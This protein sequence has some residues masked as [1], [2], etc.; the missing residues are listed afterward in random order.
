MHKV[1]MAWIVVAG[2]FYSHQPAM[3]D[4]TTAVAARAEKIDSE[5]RYNRLNNSVEELFTANLALQKRVAALTEEVDRLRGELR[6]EKNRTS[7]SAANYASQED[8]GN[9]I[10]KLKELDEKRDA[11]NKLIVEEVRKLIKS[12][13]APA[14]E[15][16]A[17]KP[18]EK[19]TPIPAKGYDYEIQPGDILSS[20]VSD[21]RKKGA[22]V[23]TQMVI[24]ANPDVIKNPDRLPV[25]KKI[26]IPDAALR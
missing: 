26:F 9:L 14:V 20:I 2:L 21:Y 4:E 23:T 25:G 3:G 5:D 1:I 22:K 8:L 17:E 12:I 13:P 16:P 24:K 7:T 15:K 11:D 19:E 10:K 18:K 6:E